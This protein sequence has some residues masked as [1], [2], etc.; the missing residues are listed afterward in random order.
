MYLVLSGSYFIG[1]LDTYLTFAHP[2]ETIQGVLGLNVM[3][4][5]LTPFFDSFFNVLVLIVP[6]ITMRTFAEERKIGTYELLISYPVHPWE[7][8]F[9][10]FLSLIAIVMT[11]LSL[12]LVFPA[13]VAW[14]GHPHWPEII[15]TYSGFVLFLFLYVALGVW[16]SILTENQLIAAIICYAVY[17]LSF[18]LGYLAHIAPA[19]L[20]QFFTNFLVRSHL[21]SFKAGLVFLGDIAVFICGTM[22]F[23]TA[24]YMRLRRHFI[25]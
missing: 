23:L 10:K 22:F 1:S 4:H 6:L 15:T 20:D 11:L 18:L 21:S 13:I 14:K 7:V 24:A 2:N 12:S 19:P 16:A 3:G 5:L 17:S 8:I 9:G 25:R